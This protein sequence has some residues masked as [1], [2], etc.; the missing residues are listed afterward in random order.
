MPSIPRDRAS[1][2]QTMLKDPR[3]RSEMNRTIGIDAQLVQRRRVQGR[4]G[5]I[6]AH[7]ADDP[8]R[9]QGIVLILDFRNIQT[10]EHGADLMSTLKSLKETM[11]SGQAPMQVPHRRQRLIL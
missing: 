7:Q 6:F 3:Q 5:V 9:R 1:E 10:L 11:R 4:V 2:T 8:E